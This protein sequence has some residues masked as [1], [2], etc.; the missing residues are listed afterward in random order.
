MESAAGAAAESTEAKLEQLALATG[1]GEQDLVGEG[2]DRLYR[3]YIGD[4]PSE[5]DGASTAP[6]SKKFSERAAEVVVRQV[7][8]ANFKLR[9]PF[10]Y[11]DRDRRFDVPE[12]DVSDF[13]SVP[14]FLTWL[15]PRYG[16]HTLAALLHD[17][18]QDHLHRPGTPIPDDPEAVT[19]DEADTVFRQ[20]MQYSHV[21]FVRRW[22]MWAAVSLRTVFKSGPAGAVVVVLWVALFALLGLAWPVAVLISVGTDQ[23]GW[24]VPLLLFG[25]AVLL[26]VL[27]CWLAWRR[28]R[29]SLISGLT[30]SLIAFP[31]VLAIVTGGIYYVVERI[32]MGLGGEKNEV[33]VKPQGRTR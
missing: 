12:H 33:I 23:V 4:P 10:K 21:P 30:L 22:V 2:V 8:P 28:W 19:S 31:C 7:T 11:V 1:R 16:R 32:A 27:L 14:S 26:P 13:A 6:F 15:I 25:A 29:L 3:I 17:H 24:R 9:E 20:A 5:T 18:L